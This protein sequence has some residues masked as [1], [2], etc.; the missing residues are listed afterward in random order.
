MKK[1]ILIIAISLALYSC[2]K[3]KKVIVENT[4]I[5]LISKVLI[6]GVSY[7]EYT[8]NDA[9]LLSEEKSK[10]N[11]TKHNYNEKNLLTTSDYYMDPGMFSSDSRVAEA[12]MNRKEW[13][14]P[15]NS[16]KSLTK[17]SEYNDKDRL[18]RVTYNRPSVTGP[19]YSEFSFENDRISR[20][21]MYRQNELSH[22]IDY[23]YDEKGN[24]IK[25]TKYRVISA[26][27]AELLTTT[28]YVFDNMHNPFQAFN[29]IMTP[30]KYTNSNN[31]IKET[32][33]IHFEV[34][35]FTQKVQ[36]T[37]NTYEYNE[38][39]YPVKVNGEAEYAYK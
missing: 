24:L 6:Y 14:N 20:Q 10:F 30:G 34:D 37:N 26:G 39:G 23:I 16:A 31:I 15:G 29:R 27:I 2:G 17:S 22:Y 38:K 35:Q 12:S 13:V 3:E 28:E 8:Y 18:T 5:P 32:Y 1:I 7:Y 36:I 19:E 4:G 33:T 25:E 21:N 9:N 11:Y